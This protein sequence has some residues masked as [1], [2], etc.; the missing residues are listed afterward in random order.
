MF[1]SSKI[2]LPS[3]L[4]QRSLIQVGSWIFLWSLKTSQGPKPH[5]NW[6]CWPTNAPTSPCFMKN[7]H[8]HPPCSYTG[9]PR[10]RTV[11]QIDIQ[12]IRAPRWETRN[13]PDIPTPKL[14]DYA[15]L[16]GSSLY[17]PN[18]PS[19]HPT[20]LFL[21]GCLGFHRGNQEPL[22]HCCSTSWKAT[23]T[24]VNV[25]LLPHQRLIDANLL[26]SHGRTMLH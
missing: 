16:S 25:V 7:I 13:I 14:T 15:P 26:R 19:C 8:I 23:L 1:R 6:G 9:S 22:T 21:K 11:Q 2:H 10:Q 3:H 5:A 12:N 18:R 17:Q 20:V 4:S 24:V